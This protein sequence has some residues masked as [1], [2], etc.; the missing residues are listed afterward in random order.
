MPLTAVGLA[1]VGV[2]A[3]LAVH[4]V[5]AGW[6]DRLA[7]GVYLRAGDTLD[8][9]AALAV[10]EQQVPGLHVGGAT[11]LDWSGVR[12][13]VAQQPVTELYGCATAKLPA[14]F[15]ER[16]PATYR[17]KRLFSETPDEPLGV[18]RWERG[19][20]HPRVSTP[21]RALLELLSEVGLRETLAGAKELVESLYTLRREELAELLRRCTSVKVVR[22]CLMLGRELQLPWAKELDSAQLPT[23][24]ARRWVA[25]TKD[26]VL[27][28]KP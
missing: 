15:T 11:A 25:R 13:Y 10:L 22:L 7:R 4:Y 21:E 14:W 20:H 9:H 12:H 24:S 1:K 17:R 23:G 16:F 2:S 3:D 5:N 27:V 26:G 8:L 28:L 19:P 6:L 18:V